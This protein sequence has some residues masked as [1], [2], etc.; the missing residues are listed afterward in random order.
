MFTYKVAIAKDNWQ[1]RTYLNYC[2]VIAYLC[3][4]GI[5]APAP[6]SKSVAWRAG[7]RS[8]WYVQTV[9]LLNNTTQQKSKNKRRMVETDIDLFEDD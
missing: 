7:V 8:E 1:E 4:F 5:P 2:Q 9:C 3:K 6:K